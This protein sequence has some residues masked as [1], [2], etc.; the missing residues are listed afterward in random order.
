MPRGGYNRKGN[1][2]VEGTRAIDVMALERRG[3]LA[4]PQ[5][6][7]LH[8]TSRNGPTASVSVTGGRDAVR[9]DYRVRVLGDEWQPVSQRIQIC[10]K[11]CHFGGQRPWF[12]CAGS[13]NGVCCGRCVTKLYGGGRLFA[14]RHCYCLGYAVQHSGPMERAHHHLARLHRYLGADYAGPDM[15]TPSKPK[16]MRWKTYSRITQQIEAGKEQLDAVFMT[17]AQRILTR[18]ERAEHRSRRRRWTQDLRRLR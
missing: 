12:V 8:W 14:C 4:G 5:L 7:S 6:G 15:S 1:G 11:P 9:L 16:W 10:W 3:Y 17:G 2:I 18:L 13:A